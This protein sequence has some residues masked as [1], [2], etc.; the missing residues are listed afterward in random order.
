MTGGAENHGDM[1]SSV[2]RCCPDVYAHP[3]H[4][5]RNVVCFCR[6]YRYLL[7]FSCV[8]TTVSMTPCA[9]PGYV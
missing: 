4:I 3:I 2:W 7:S 9:L 5:P 6:V 1:L 8:E